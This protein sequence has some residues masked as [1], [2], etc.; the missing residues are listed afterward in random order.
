MGHRRF[1]AIGGN[2]TRRA[3]DVIL[4]VAIGLR[5]AKLAGPGEHCYE[6]AARPH[7]WRMTDHSTAIVAPLARWSCRIA[8]FSVSLLLVSLVLHR[9]T[10]FST[11]VAMNLFLVGYAGAAMAILIG[12]VAFVQIWRTGFGGA[13]SVA[14]GVLMPLLMFAG[15][16]GYAV[17][18]HNLPPHQRCDDRSGVTA[19][20]RGAGQAHRRGQLQRLSGPEVRRAADARPIPTCVPW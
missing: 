18:F 15:P 17:A 3:L 14:V 7:G 13:A 16:V 20:V 1:V 6:R 5:S 4:Q 8:L 2:R 9:V 10:S 11:A 19:E 12:A